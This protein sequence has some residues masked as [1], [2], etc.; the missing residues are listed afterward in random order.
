[1]EVVDALLVAEGRPQLPPAT[2]T[3]VAQI[4]WYEEPLETQMYASERE[5]SAPP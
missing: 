2:A 3:R 5:R 4:E 1:M